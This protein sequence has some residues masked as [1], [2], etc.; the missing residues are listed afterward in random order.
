MAIETVIGERIATLR[1][2]RG[3]TQTELAQTANLNRSFISEIEN[4]HKNISIATLHKIAK[5]LQ[6]TMVTLVEGLDDIPADTSSQ[7]E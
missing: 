4:G 2:S 6:V 3:V 1:K 7:P 5:A